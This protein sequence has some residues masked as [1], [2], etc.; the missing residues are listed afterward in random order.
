MSDYASLCLI[1]SLLSLYGM[2][3]LINYFMGRFSSCLVPVDL[4]C[5][6]MLFSSL[7][8]DLR[9]LQGLNEA[10]VVQL[11]PHDHGCTL[12]GWSRVHANGQAIL[13]T[14]PELATVQ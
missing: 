10:M 6:A 2:M 1:L 13:L 9:D 4:G 14:K 12:T 8:L 5:G 7:S 3:I 11:C